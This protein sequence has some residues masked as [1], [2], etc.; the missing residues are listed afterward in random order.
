MFLIQQI[1]S[2]AFQKQTLILPSGE[3]FDLTINFK[4]MQYGWFIT[5]LTY[6]GFKLN[7]V[8]ICTSPNFIYQFKNQ[9]PFGLACFTDD[10]SEPQLKQ[11]F[12]SGR[13]KLYVLTQEEVNLYTELLSGQVSA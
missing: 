11:D 12:S 2:E 7:G 9:I 6:K 8:R 1:T 5:E 10:F 4:P 13:A 3:S